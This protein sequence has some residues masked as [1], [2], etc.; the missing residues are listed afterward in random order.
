MS[1]YVYKS[2][3]D[4]ERPTKNIKG[5]TFTFGTSPT[6][7]SDQLILNELVPELLDRYV[8]GVKS[9]D[10]L[11]IPYIEST[12]D[13]QKRGLIDQYTAAQL[14]AFAAAGGL[15]PYATYVASDS[16]VWYRATSPNSL[17][18]FSGGADAIDP[19]QSSSGS[20]APSG[21]VV[22]VVRSGANE[23]YRIGDNAAGALLVRPGDAL[24]GAITVE[25]HGSADTVAYALQQCGYVR[26]TG[27]ATIKIGNA[28]I[29]ITQSHFLAVLCRINKAVEVEGVNQLI[30][31]IRTTQVTTG[32]NRQLCVTGSANS[33]PSSVCRRHVTLQGEGFTTAP[34]TG[35]GTKR[36]VSD[37]SSTFRPNF[38][39]AIF[40]DIYGDD[41]SG[42]TN[43]A[44]NNEWVWMFCKGTGPANLET[45]MAS[46][47]ADGVAAQAQ[48]LC[49]GHMWV[50]RHGLSIPNSRLMNV[51][52]D[53]T[54]STSNA[55]SPY[56]VASFSN[57]DFV[58]GSNAA[59]HVIDVAAV[60]HLS[61]DPRTLDMA[62]M[63]QGMHP[64]DMGLSPVAAS[65]FVVH[66]GSKAQADADSNAAGV[67]ATV[68]E[69]PGTGSISYNS[70]GGP[71]LLRKLGSATSTP[72][73]IAS[74]AGVLA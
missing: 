10:N 50:P 72:L 61:R 65:D 37:W 15:T 43:E 69:T 51:R 30:N 32:Y 8:D 44:P 26:I 13:K 45:G 62:L 49:V 18:F 74:T 52:Y 12:Q 68:T 35:P 38:S 16:G 63:M 5:I 28:N 11:I 47:N 22:G 25:K 23:T 31:V 41:G 53:V 29:A 6:F 17:A 4:K 40:P 39:S 57:Q 34:S 27:D 46:L 36:V 64:A 55:V 3:N 2:F 21:G 19:P 71:V 48:T 54:H 60:I 42:E 33:T 70:S 73:S 66:F 1:T 20:P 14:T 56:M 67:G 9:N 7:S 59:G 24:T 58:I